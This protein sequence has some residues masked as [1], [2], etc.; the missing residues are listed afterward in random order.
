MSTSTVDGRV[1]RGLR[2]YDSTIGKKVVMAVTGVMLFGFIISHMAANLQ[3]FA[4]PDALNGYAVKLRELGPLLWAA[5]IG[6]LV[7]VVLHI[8]ASF[9]LIALQNAARPV[10][11]AR[12]AS[13][14]STYASRTMRWSGPI[15]L[16]FLIYHL[17][18]FTF[19]NVHPQFEDL[20]P[21]ENVVVGFR[22]VPV[23]IAY[24]VAMGMLCLHL[25][26]GLWSM[27]QTLGAAHPRYTPKIKTFAGLTALG[28]FLGFVIVPVA[29]L[30]GW[31]Q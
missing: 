21:Y 12:R 23:V 1:S 14:G 22:S 2:F 17:M 24:L 18:H 19:G 9:Q 6:L 15:L 28:I 10:G 30:A 26:H 20:R 5:R 13:V 16:A 4:G 8:V 11:Y 25:Q 31:V 27:F 7:A 29:V 3:V